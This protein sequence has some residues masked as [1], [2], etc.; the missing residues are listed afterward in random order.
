ML[1]TWRCTVCSLRTRHWAIWRSPSPSAIEPKH[2]SLAGRQQRTRR[3]GLLPQRSQ[4]GGGARC[5][6]GCAEPGAVP[7][8]PLGRC[9]G[10]ILDTQSALNLRERQQRLGGFEGQALLFVDVDRCLEAGAGRLRG[11]AGGRDGALGVGG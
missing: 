9:D 2:L 8:R 1:E 4:Q 10:E 6:R 3:R 7:Q 11:A 5:D